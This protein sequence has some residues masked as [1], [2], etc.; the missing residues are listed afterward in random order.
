MFLNKL[1]QEKERIESK[2]DLGLWFKNDRSW[3]DN[4]TIGVQKE[5]KTGQR[6][7]GQKVRK[8]IC[9]P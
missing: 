2:Y 7:I 3:T 6:S 4:C 8:I 5:S 9:M 1:A